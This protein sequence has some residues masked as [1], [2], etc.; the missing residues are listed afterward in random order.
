MEIRPEETYTFEH[1]GHVFV[2]NVSKA[3]RL[4]EQA[5]RDIDM[6]RPAEQGVTEDHLR[7]RYPD[8][9]EEYAKTTDLSRPLLFVPYNGAA[10]LF[11]GWHRLFKAVRNKVSEL[12]AYLLTEEEAN[13]C[14]ELHIP[15][16]GERT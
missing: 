13:A 5:P 14:L 8:L 2:W 7:E 9:D 15:P 3:W 11:D 6:F 16:K 12:P 1:A 10:Q 4:I